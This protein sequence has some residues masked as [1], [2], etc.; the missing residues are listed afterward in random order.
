MRISYWILAIILIIFVI[1]FILKNRIIY[2]PVAAI[3]EK[4]SIF[5]S[6]LEKLTGIPKSFQ[7]YYIKTEDNCLLDSILIKNPNS[8]KCI[9][10]FHGSS[11]NISTRYDLIKFLYNFAS[12][13]IFDYRS[14]GLSSGNY[15]SLSKNNLQKD[16]YAVWEFVINKI[17]INPSK[18]SLFGESIG[19]SVAVRLLAEISKTNTKYYPRSIILNYPFSRGKYSIM[20]GFLSFWHQEFNLTE[21]FS[22]TN[23]QTKI[24]IADSLQ[25]GINSFNSGYQIYRKLSTIRPNNVKFVKIFGTH[26]N[27]RFTDNYVYILAELFE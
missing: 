18:I 10:I 20:F 23:H 19:C 8:S 12:I 6:K 14:F 11:G 21:L 1:L 22:L 4:Y 16:A 2:D 17:G 3:P 7:K 15:Y 25:S 27:P 5:Y 9:I 13:V 24:V 26:Q